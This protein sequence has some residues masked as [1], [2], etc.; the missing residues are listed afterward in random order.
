[1]W[2]HSGRLLPYYQITVLFQTNGS[3][4][5]TSL[6]HLGM[7]YWR[8]IFH[9][10]PRVI[11]TGPKVKKF[12]GVN[13]TFNGLTSSVWSLLY[14][15]LLTSNAGVKITAI[16]LSHL[17]EPK[18]QQKFYKIELMA[19]YQ[20]VGGGVVGVGVPAMDIIHK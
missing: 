19:G 10:G 12:F 11:S 1:M 3:D 13:Y 2:S 8:K 20:K 18:N 17:P 4:K 14:G 16:L 7:N 5:L 9:A 15:L 6:F